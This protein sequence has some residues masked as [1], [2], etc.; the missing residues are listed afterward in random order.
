MKLASLGWGPA[1]R[2][3]ENSPGE[4]NGQPG[5]RTTE[6]K[7]A[8][9]EKYWKLQILFKTKALLL[10]WPAV[11]SWGGRCG[12]LLLLI[13]QIFSSLPT[14]SPKLLIAL[15]LRCVGREGGEEGRAG[16][17]DV[18]GADAIWHGS[19]WLWQRFKADSFWGWARTFV[20]SSETAFQVW[21]SLFCS[22]LGFSAIWFIEIY[23]WCP[24]SPS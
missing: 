14:L 1:I 3:L 8:V 21:E 13:L 22:S 4:S 2:N 18:T 6:M 24:R 23:C 19:L 5:L 17:F 20:Y 9:P 7:C 10:P 11:L 16:G 12:K 15:W